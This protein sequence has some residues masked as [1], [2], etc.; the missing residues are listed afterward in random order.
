MRPRRSTGK[1][2]E[3]IRRK[4]ANV[5]KVDASINGVKGTFIIDTGATFVTVKKGFAEKAG[6]KIAGERVKLNTANGNRRRLS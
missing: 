5:I 1:K 3:T 4:G 6:I 2:E